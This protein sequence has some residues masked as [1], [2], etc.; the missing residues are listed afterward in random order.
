MVE[1]SVARQ[2]APDVKPEPFLWTATAEQI[3]T[4]VQRGRIALQQNTTQN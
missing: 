3:I 2:A 1:L 4:K